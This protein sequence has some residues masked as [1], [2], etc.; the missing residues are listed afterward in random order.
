MEDQVLLDEKTVNPTTSRKINVRAIFHFFL[1]PTIGTLL[2]P[3]IW[4][5]TYTA[6]RMLTIPQSSPEG[7]FTENSYLEVDSTI[8]ASIWEHAAPSHEYSP[9]PCPIG[10][11]ANPL[12]P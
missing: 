7:L 12:I 2:I 11:P 10:R 5:S 9:P 6:H 4:K 8:F 3:S 1:G